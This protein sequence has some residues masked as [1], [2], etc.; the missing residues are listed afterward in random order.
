MLIGKIQEKADPFLVSFVFGC[1]FIIT[2]LLYVVQ[3]GEARGESLSSTDKY[4]DITFET[5]LRKSK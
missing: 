1:I 3:H 5:P 2:I 4:Y